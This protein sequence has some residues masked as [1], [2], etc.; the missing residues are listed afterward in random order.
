MS[1]IAFGLYSTSIYSDLT[2]YTNQAMQTSGLSLGQSF[3]L[4][5]RTHINDT[6]L[7]IVWFWLIGQSGNAQL[8]PASIA[9][10]EYSIIGYIFTDYSTT[11][12]YS[13]RQYALLLV[14]LIVSLPLYNSVA[15][16]RSTP[17]MAI[18][19][20]GLYLVFVK[21]VK[22][23]LVFSLFIVSIL[24]HS[25]GFIFIPLVFLC[26]IGKNRPMIA[27]LLAIALLPVVFFSAY[28]LEPIF[29]Y[30]GFSVVNKVQA[31]VGGSESEYAL[32]VLSSDYLQ[33]KKWTSIA[34]ASVALVLQ[35]HIAARF[36]KNDERFEHLVI[37]GIMLCA[38]VVSFG[39]LI[40]VPSYARFLYTAVPISILVVTGAILNTSITNDF[41]RGGFWGLVTVLFFVLSLAVIVVA[42]YDVPRRI[43]IGLLMNHVLLGFFGTI[44]L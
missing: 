39:I 22:N 3:D 17:A 38:N 40:T 2:T 44:L 41:E 34:W 26:Q 29:S 36:C 10:V 35:C 9:F 11:R 42:L 5:S 13:R 19:L 24:I 1:G 30:F 20:L 8:Y 37:I 27:V 31:Y 18:G 4:F 6:P 14:L 15:S 23:P 33:V 12:G 43:A 21:E 28:T 7:A 16:V 25:V 32:H